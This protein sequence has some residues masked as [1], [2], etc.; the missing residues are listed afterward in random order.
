MRKDV[1]VSNIDATNLN[2]YFYGYENCSP[3]HAYGPAVRD[4][5]LFVYIRKGKGI[6]RDENRTFT[7]GTGESFFIFPGITTYYESDANEPWEYMWIGFFGDRVSKYLAY[8]G[9][10]PLNPVHRHRN[11]KRIEE[12]FD[13]LFDRASIQGT[14]NEIYLIG[15]LHLIFSELIKDAQKSCTKAYTHEGTKQD[16]AYIQKALHFISMNYAETI[17][18]TSIAS[19][20]GLERSYFSKLFKKKTGSSPHAFLR[21][22]R[23]KKAVMLLENTVMPIEHIA[24]SVGFEYP[25]YFSR[26]FKKYMGSCPLEYRKMANSLGP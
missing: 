21:D 3:R 25:L 12:L 19:H 4:H 23:L 1:F 15:I 13:R 16:D 26:V 22:Y 20:V 10:N 14:H 11:V 9:I 8:A 5:Y 6:L 2:M 17:S 7:L 18:T 24:Y